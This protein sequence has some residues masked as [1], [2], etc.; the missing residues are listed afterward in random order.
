M[1]LAVLCGSGCALL[2][3]RK[4]HS[5]IMAGSWWRPGGRER[6][7]NISPAR[8]IRINYSFLIIAQN[9]QA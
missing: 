2:V 3:S 8:L 4:R 6:G 5:W 9:Y 7:E 1:V